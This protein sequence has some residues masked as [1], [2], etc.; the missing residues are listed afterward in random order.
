VFDERRKSRLYKRGSGRHERRRGTRGIF[1]VKKP[2]K[3]KKGLKHASEFRN[4]RDL[5]RGQLREGKEKKH[6]LTT[7]FLLKRD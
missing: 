4:E 5:E 6:R 2:V 1:V 7:K 3:K